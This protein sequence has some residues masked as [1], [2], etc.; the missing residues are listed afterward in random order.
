MADEKPCI[1]CKKRKPLED[2]PVDRHYKDGRTNRCRLCRNAARRDYREANAEREKANGRD[3]YGRTKEQ[4]RSY[5]RKRAY[6]VSQ[7]EFDRMAE[8]QNG[9][10]LICGNPPSGKG[11]SNI[12][13]VDHCHDT[14]RIRGLLCTNCNC[15][16]GFFKDD[17]ELV[18]K[19]LFY[20]EGGGLGDSPPG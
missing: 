6:G 19:A 16:I 1:G 8:A 4:I 12:L 20:L 9:V 7:E 17:P 18:K 14:G 11:K 5:N 3:R 15:G 13:H 2:F 10:C